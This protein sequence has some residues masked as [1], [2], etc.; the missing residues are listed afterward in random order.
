MTHVAIIVVDMIPGCI[1]EK[2]RI[3]DLEELA[4]QIESIKKL[5]STKKPTYLI[6]YGR[7][8]LGYGHTLP[9][10]TRAAHDPRVV[11]KKWDSAFY[12][13]TLDEQLRARGTQHIALC[14]INTSACVYYTARDAQRLGYNVITS[15]DLISDFEWKDPAWKRFKDHELPYFE[16][17]TT[18][19][20]RVEE[21]IAQL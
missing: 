12:D 1:N 16:R 14:G 21:V 15:R 10:I 8:E 20:E 7:L 3:R 6:E 17:E 13:T 5:A 18:F 9:E 2:D 11:Y 4:R 19:F